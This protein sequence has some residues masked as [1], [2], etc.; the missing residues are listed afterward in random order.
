[1][2]LLQKIL[3]SVTLSASSLFAHSLWINNFESHAHA[4]G[5]SM[6]SLGWG[7]SLPAGDKLNSVKGRV[8]IDSFNFYDP[9][10]KKFELYKP[11]Y[12]PAKATLENKNF[13]LYR[14]DL[15]TQKIALKKDSQKGVYQLEVK[16][17]PTF[18]TVYID[19]KGRKRTKLKAKDE[20]KNLKKTIASIKYQGFAKSYI[21]INKWE[22]PEPLGHDLEIIPLTDLSNVSAGDLVEFYFTFKGKPISH[23]PKGIKYATFFSNTYGQ[24]DGFKLMSKIKKGKAQVRVPTSGQWLV[25]VYNI[26][27][28]T[29]DGDT[30]SLFGKTD[31]LMNGASISFNVK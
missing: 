20:I 9:N 3:L 31:T 14:A 29:K 16:S 25:N 12:K 8:M 1:M 21:T 6:V 26:Q 24:S 13:D 5:H 18:Y 2:K 30:K 15:A 4:P 23:S 7:H 10:L 27:A 28:V 11:V 19:E 17:I 22:K